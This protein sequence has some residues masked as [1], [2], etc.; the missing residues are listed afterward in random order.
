MEYRYIKTPNYGVKTQENAPKWSTDT[1]KPPI[2]EYQCKKMPI[3]AVQTHEKRP[4]KEEHENAQL[5]S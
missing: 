1:W 5:R 4:T 2:T 3:Y